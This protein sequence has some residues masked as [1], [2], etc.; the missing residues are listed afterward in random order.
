MPYQMT[1]D[2]FSHQGEWFERTKDSDS[3]GFFWEMGCG[4]T[5]PILDTFGHLSWEGK[6]TGC[7]VV[8]PNMVHRNWCVNEIPLHCP[9]LASCYWSPQKA[10]TKRYEKEC[11]HFLE[12][13]SRNQVLAVS[14]E[15]LTAKHWKA[16]A[17]AF[18]K[19][20]SGRL[21]MVCD[22]SQYIKSPKA[23]RT[24]TIL[25][26]SGFAKYR[27]IA[28]GT[29]VTQ[30]PF[31]IFTQLKFLR[32]TFW[33]GYG[34]D[35]YYAFSHTFGEFERAFSRTHQFELLKEYRNLDTL[36]NIV[37]TISSRLTKEEV[38]D[39]PDKLYQWRTFEIKGKQAKLYQKAKNETEFW[40]NSTDLVSIPIALT[41]MLKLQQILGGFIPVET[42]IVPCPDCEEDDLSADCDKC[43]GTG[44]HAEWNNKRKVVDIDEKNPRAE[45]VADIIEELPRHR[46]VIVWSRFTRMIDLLEEEFAKRAKDENAMFSSVRYDG[47][48]GNSERE[49]ALDEFVSGRAR[50]FLGNPA[51]GGTGLTLVQAKTVIYCDNSF[52]LSHRQQSE[53]RAHRIGQTSD[54]TYIDIA[55][56]HNGEPTIDNHI[57]E[58]LRLKR[59]V[60]A[61]CTGD[62]LGEWI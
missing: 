20:H 24:K 25:K 22:E 50:I 47:T 34:L 41:R 21:M 52:H 44:I 30:G 17:N 27:R 28:T 45:L 53:D 12:S 40:L 1:T 5:K 3:F 49:Q 55:A 58:N 57:A 38:L 7:L 37:D 42:P 4:K 13:K 51:A 36:K 61:I 23:K 8:A 11:S 59:D 56:I 35:T 6:A 29:P 31:D 19:K 62:T 33:K 16:M 18:V 54:V 39:L 9:E 32:E 48:V 2:P 46:Q 15:S 10:G 26:A 14:Y 43:M 60:A